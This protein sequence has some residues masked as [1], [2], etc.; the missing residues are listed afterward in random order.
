MKRP[1]A[2]RWRSVVCCCFRLN[3]MHI[4]AEPADVWLLEDTPC[5]QIQTDLVEGLWLLSPSLKIRFYFKF[6]S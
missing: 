6:C 3:K 1:F 4:Q 5:S 2:Q